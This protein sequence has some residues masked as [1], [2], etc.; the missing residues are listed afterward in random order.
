MKQL[1]L[2]ALA[3][4]C[5]AGLTSFGTAHA[6]DAHKAS[7][8]TSASA[9]STTADCCAGKS[10]KAT[11]ASMQACADKSAKSGKVQASAAG[12]SAASMDCCMSKGASASKAGFAGKC[13]STSATSAVAAG[14]CAAHGD[15][16]MA[17][18]MDCSA[19]EDWSMCE[20]QVHAMGGHSQVVALKNGVMIVY[21]A[22]APEGVR[23]V[24]AAIARRGESVKNSLTSR[25]ADAKLCSDCKQLRGALASGKLH[26]EV[27]N[28]EKGA[29]DLLTSNDKAVV[30]MIHSLTGAQIA[31]H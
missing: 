30:Q 18:A 11:A 10:T 23:A 13:L 22:D 3:T 25:K 27:V 8:G 9:A 21:T 31:A 24:Q 15:Q 19:C 1:R 26:R 6:C 7:K 4:C 29:M 17:M 2:L 14:G 16:A 12:N 28:V 20:M 5:A